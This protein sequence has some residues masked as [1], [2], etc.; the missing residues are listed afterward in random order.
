VTHC[1]AVAD[2]NRA[3]FEWYAACGEDSFLYRVTDSLEVKVSR[4]NVCVTVRD[5]D[6]RLSHVIIL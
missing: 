6:E 3:E 5:A 2:C 1:D 4:D